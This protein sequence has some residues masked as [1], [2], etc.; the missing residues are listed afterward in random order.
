[1]T[2]PRHPYRTV[3][4]VRWLDP[5][6]RGLSGDVARFICPLL[7]WESYIEISFVLA[8]TTCDNAILAGR[9]FVVVGVEVEIKVRI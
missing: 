7:G 4:V 3:Y 5:T 9:G 6:V 1:V 2:D 8:Q